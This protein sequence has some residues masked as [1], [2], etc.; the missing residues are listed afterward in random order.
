MFAGDDSS[1]DE[2]KRADPYADRQKKGMTSEGGQ[3]TCTACGTSDTPKWRHGEGWPA[4]VR[5]QCHLNCPRRLSS[6]AFLP[7]P[8]HRHPYLALHCQWGIATSLTAHPSISHSQGRHYAKHAACN[9]ESGRM[10]RI[11]S[12]QR[13]GACSRRGCLTRRRFRKR[14]SVRRVP[15]RR[16]S[17]SSRGGRPS[18]AWRRRPPWRGPPHRRPAA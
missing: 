4:A 15:S 3:R 17:Q 13:L 8:C 2:R 18:R 7:G 11:T 6:R 5:E 12:T 9:V 16:S 1:D 14:R 10:D